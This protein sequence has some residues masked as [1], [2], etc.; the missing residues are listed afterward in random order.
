MRT[1]LGNLTPDEPGMAA[2]ITS[3]RL[4]GKGT[5]ADNHAIV[6]RQRDQ[7]RVRPSQ[8]VPACRRLL[9]HGASLSRAQGVAAG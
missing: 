4:A 5:A 3:L 1:C 8:D 7:R 6:S 9:D 2:S